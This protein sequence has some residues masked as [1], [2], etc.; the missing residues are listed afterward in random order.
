MGSRMGIGK[1]V[2]YR[3]WEIPGAISGW[4]AE[5]LAVRAR[6][7]RPDRPSGPKVSLLIRIAVEL[8]FHSAVPSDRWRSKTP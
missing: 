4:T 3:D 7:R 8:T 5:G 6:K 2:A 1:E